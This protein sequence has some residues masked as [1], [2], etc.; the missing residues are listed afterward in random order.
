MFNYDGDDDNELGPWQNEEEV[1][2]DDEENPQDFGLASAA[3]RFVYKPLGP[4]KIITIIYDDNNQT[5]GALKNLSLENHKKEIKGLIS[6][7]RSELDLDSEEILIPLKLEDIINYVFGRGVQDCSPFM[8]TIKAKF[9][10][11]LKDTN[12]NGQSPRMMNW[13]LDSFIEATLQ[14]HIYQISPDELWA[15]EE[16]WYRQ[17]L[18]TKCRFMFIHSQI[19]AFYSDNNREHRHEWRPRQIDRTLPEIVQ[20]FTELGARFQKVAFLR[21]VTE[22]SLDD[23]KEHIRSSDVLRLGMSRTFQRGGNPGPTIMMAFSKGLGILLAAR[24]LELNE[25]SQTCAERTLASKIPNDN[26]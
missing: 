22:I 20:A 24:I 12:K 14:L 17:P 8:A 2:S 5:L 3:N 10:E 23:E 25:S 4:D 15:T 19:T 16:G 18:M 6:N 9:K 1:F 11:A 26:D 21:G 7:I 13:E